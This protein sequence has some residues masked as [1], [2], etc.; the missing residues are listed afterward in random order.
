MEAE[1]GAWEPAVAERPQTTATMTTNSLQKKKHK[2][3]KKLR[4]KS[5][6][7]GSAKG[8]DSV[9]EEDVGATTKAP[10]LDGRDP[11]AQEYSTVD[12]CAAISKASGKAT[13]AVATKAAPPPPPPS[14]TGKISDRRSDPPDPQERPVRTTGQ[15]PVQVPGSDIS[16]Y[17]CFY[18][19]PKHG[20]VKAGWLDK[21]SPHGNYVFQ[22]RWVRFDGESLAY[23]NNDK[24][25]VRASRRHLSHG[26]VTPR[27]LTL[28]RPNTLHNA[29]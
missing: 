7:E 6:Q 9:T 16:P 3:Q 8:K 24:S 29:A 26:F 13:F 15:V 22:R 18:G 12:E 27:G 1:P 5:D 21:L 14:A 25:A 4:N 10:R 28:W 11:Y 17:A 20:A 2:K 19:A 23:Y